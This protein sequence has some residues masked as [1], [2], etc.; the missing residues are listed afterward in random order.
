M[1]IDRSPSE[2]NELV[3]NPNPEFNNEVLFL[4]VLIEGRASL[5]EYTQR[6]ISRFFYS[7]DGQEI[8]QLVFKYYLAGNGQKKKNEQFKQQLLS[9]LQCKE[10]RRSEIDR[11]NYTQKDLTRLFVV[12]N[13]CIGV[14]YVNYAEKKGK[15]VYHISLRPGLN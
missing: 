8:N 7:I 4:K 15:D 6:N 12:N 3:R 13:D 9:D 11:L 1:A 5:D 14:G 2:M 10:L